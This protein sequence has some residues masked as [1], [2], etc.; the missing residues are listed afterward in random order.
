MTTTS[1]RIT[2]RP[3]EVTIR[4]QVVRVVSVSAGGGGGIGLSDVAGITAPA[5]NVSAHGAAGDGASDDTTAIR[6]AIAAAGVNGTLSFPRDTTFLV[7]DE[8]KPLAGQT[9]LMDGVTLTIPDESA[10][11]FTANATYVQGVAPLNEVRGIIVINGVDRVTIQGVT[12]DG[13]GAAQNGANIVKFA[14]I[15]VHDAEGVVLDRC[16]VSEIIYHGQTTVGETRQWG[17][18]FSRSAYCEVRGGSYRRA[19]YENIGVRDGCHDITITGAYCLDGATHAAQ[20]CCSP[21]AVTG[22]TRSTTTVTVTLTGHGW[23]TGDVVTIAGATQADYNIRTPIT[24]TGANTFTFEITA[25]PTTPATGTITAALRPYA[26]TWIGCTFETPA[27]KTSDGLIFHDADGCQAI[28]CTFLDGY[29]HDITSNDSVLTA[30]WLENRNRAVQLVSLN[31]SNRPKLTANTFYGRTVS[32]VQNVIQISSTSG[33]ATHGLLFANN[34]VKN[35]SRGF[36]ADPPAATDCLGWII[37][38]NNFDTLSTAI[39]LRGQVVRALIAGNT[40]RRTPSGNPSFGIDIADTCSA[41][42]IRDNDLMA[43]TN[44]ANRVVL[45][46]T[47]PTTHILRTNHGVADTA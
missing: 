35:N 29:F 2:E 10:G 7:S 4:N 25:A 36:Q 44:A 3:N 23:A 9:W 11:D 19:G 30:S 21:R 1:V 40:F 39:R 24:V 45:A 15:L 42:L 13:N 47:N 6:A 41:C 33:L 37:R 20:T 14:G 26:V 32:A 16:H 22:I 34:T 38:D 12:I 17:A 28:G 46:G 8:L 18:L 31:G 43:I 5:V 27:G